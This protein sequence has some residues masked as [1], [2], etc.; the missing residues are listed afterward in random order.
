MISLAIFL[1]LA[2]IGIGS[3]LACFAMRDMLHIVV[4]L[5]ALFTFNSLVFAML[6]QPLL[7]VVQLFVMVG[8]ISTF[9]FVGVASATYSNFRYTKVARLLLASAA[10]FAVIGYPLLGLQMYA[11]QPPVF[12]QSSIVAS[13]P[14]SMYLFYVMALV[15]FGMTLGSIVLLRRSSVSR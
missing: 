4:A 7:A 12:S 6:G 2:A 14:Q 15:M 11:Y 13:I 9:L 8:G 1:I 5:S 3:A 10:V